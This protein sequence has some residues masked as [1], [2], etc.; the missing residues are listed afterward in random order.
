MPA[1]ASKV[2]SSQV[3]FLSWGPWVLGQE[4]PEEEAGRHVGACPPAR[5]SAGV[6][7]VIT[8]CPRRASTSDPAAQ[9]S[10]P[11]LPVSSSH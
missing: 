11:P 8:V 6:C 10:H 2:G 3:S 7:S 1:V 5:V 4:R 9:G